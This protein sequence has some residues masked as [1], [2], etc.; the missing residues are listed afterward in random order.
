MPSNHTTDD[1]NPF[2]MPLDQEVFHLRELERRQRQEK[3]QKLLSMNIVEKAEA[4]MD[5]HGPREVVRAKKPVMKRPAFDKG[6]K[7]PSELHAKEGIAKAELTEALS[8]LRATKRQDRLS[9]RDLLVKKRELF[10]VQMSLDLKREEI[11]QLEEK[12]AKREKELADAET[13]LEQD[14][15]RFDEFLKANDLEAVQAIKKAEMETKRRLEKQA[16]IKRLNMQV[17]AVKSDISKSQD[18]LNDCNRYKAFLESLAP[19]EWLDE[20]KGSNELYFT[21]PQ[22]LLDTFSTLEESNL[23][24]IQTSQEAEESLELLTSQLEVARREYEEEKAALTEQVAG[25]EAMIHRA[26]SA[27]QDWSPT[28]SVEQDL[29]ALH[30]VVAEACR[31]VGIEVGNSGAVELMAKLEDRLEGLIKTATTLP[32][33]ILVEAEGQ[34]ERERRQAVREAK[35][36]AQKAQQEERLQRALERAQQPPFKRTT[37]P[38]MPRSYLPKKEKRTRTTKKD[39]VEELCNND[40][41]A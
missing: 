5:E 13:L 36:Q 34:R 27:S 33:K 29:S 32:E 31:S 4:Y 14:S 26:G 23:F 24:L 22:Q 10:L 15:V 20:H 7:Q 28:A 37:K 6:L 2:K 8:Q 21:Q 12:A 16:E 25:L 38:P 3:R 30:E 41:F 40:F 35:L 19:A 9:T 39:A 1:E 17:L 11:R 18:Q